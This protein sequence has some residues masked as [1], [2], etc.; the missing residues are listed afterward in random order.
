[1]NDTPTGNARSRLRDRILACVLFVVAAVLVAVVWGQVLWVSSLRVD[2][3]PTYLAGR[4]WSEGHYD[5]IYHPSV[6][7]TEQTADPAWLELAHKIAPL[8]KLQETS[9][10]Y[11]PW[12]LMLVA[13][14]TRVMSIEQFVAFWFWLNV[15]SAVWIGWEAM[16]WAGR[17]ASW[18][19]AAGGLLAGVMSPM[20]YGAW[21]GQNV[22]PCLALVMLGVRFAHGGKALQVPSGLLFTL[23]ALFKPWAILLVPLLGLTRRWIPFVAAA[24]AS[25]VLMA[26]AHSPLVPQATRDDYKG[27]NDALV[28]MTNVA[29]NNHSV[30]SL[31]E[32]LTDARWGE[33]IRTWTSRMVE[34]QIR[35]EAL[36]IAAA[37][38]AL[39]AWPFWK[40]RNDLRRVVA[41][42]LPLVLIPLG[43]CWTHYLILLVPAMWMLMFGSTKLVPRIIA[44]LGCVLFLTMPYSDAPVISRVF[45]RAPKADV[46]AI[47]P[48]LWALWY[49]LPLV[50]GIALSFMLLA[51]GRGVKPPCSERSS[52][53]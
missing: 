13:P 42:G 22:G 15:V 9:F 35:L 21:L 24:T 1:M 17:T 6:F 43:I 28:N 27:L 25:L 11:S 20:I 36:G 31:L 44:W 4:L 16:G 19:R 12:Y 29:F 5:A 8:A 52:S 38:A 18:Q 41:A 53:P 49:L 46:I 45:E 26:G 50:L 32:R 51:A 48:H 39:A 33:G 23:A 3:Q 34:P 7:L 14:L 37:I 40:N 10:V 30:R 47:H 2:L